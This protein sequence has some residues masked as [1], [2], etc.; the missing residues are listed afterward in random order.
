MRFVCSGIRISIILV[1]LLPWDGVAMNSPRSSDQRHLGAFIQAPKHMLQQKSCVNLGRQKKCIPGICQLQK[2]ARSSLPGSLVHLRMKALSTVES[3]S[4][5]VEEFDVNEKEAG[6]S[7][8]FTKKVWRRLQEFKRKRWYTQP[9]SPCTVGFLLIFWMT[10]SYFSSFFWYRAR[11]Q[12]GLDG[13]E[14]VCP[15]SHF[16]ISLAW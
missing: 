2:P 9:T 1:C 14:D 5:T 6:T 7:Y 3:P 13:A 11:E 15:Q 4:D 12:G 8:S 16:C 10:E